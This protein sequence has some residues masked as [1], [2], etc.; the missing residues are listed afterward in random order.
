MLQHTKIICGRVGGPFGLGGPGQWPIWPV[1]K[2]ALRDVGKTRTAD[3]TWYAPQPI[4]ARSAGKSAFYRSAGLRS[5]VRVLPTP[6][7]A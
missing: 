1:V 4:A 5:A 2:T 7:W 3:I 6:G